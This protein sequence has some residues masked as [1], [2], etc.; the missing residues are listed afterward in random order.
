[1]SSRMS[2]QERIRAMNQTM[3]RV[4]SHRNITTTTI[5]NSFNSDS[6][7]TNYP[8]PPLHI[9][10]EDATVSTMTTFRDFDDFD[11][12]DDD[13]DSEYE[14]EDEGKRVSVVD[15]WRKREVSSNNN[16]PKK[17]ARKTNTINNNATIINSL[18]QKQ[19]DNQ[20]QQQTTSVADLMKQ[21]TASLKNKPSPVAFPKQSKQG[22]VASASLANMF[23][24]R[25]GI[26]V[27]DNRPE[28]C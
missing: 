16:T 6:T 20:Q 1:M 7:A 27:K 14:D 26:E 18:K 10:I 19:E 24:Q 11:D 22:V 15:M 5:D 28:S 2:I 8:H 25:S 9:P 13:E 23:A 21:R 3:D 17:P 12:E 4:D